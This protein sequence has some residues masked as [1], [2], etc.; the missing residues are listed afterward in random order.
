[1][2]PAVNLNSLAQAQVGQAPQRRLLAELNI[3]IQ[4]TLVNISIHEAPAMC[5]NT[6]LGAGVSLG[7]K[8][9]S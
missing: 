3:L 2:L 6:D 4:F 8:I 5:L 1:M 9:Q 7:D